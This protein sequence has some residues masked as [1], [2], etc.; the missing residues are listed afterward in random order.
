MAQQFLSVAPRN[1]HRAEIAV[2]VQGRFK[3]R[4]LPFWTVNVSASG[5][6]IK[7][8]EPLSKGEGISFSF[9]LPDRTQV[10][11]YGEIARVAQMTTIP[12]AYVYGIKFL[13]LDQGAASSIE[14]AVNKY[15][16]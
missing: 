12:Y 9:A 1:L 7:S 8:N 3:N 13:S 10:S 16:R 11:G 4:T 6:L 5:M 14:A 2:A 15:L